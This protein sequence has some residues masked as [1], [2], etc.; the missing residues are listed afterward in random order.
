[1]PRFP[2]LWF[3]FTLLASLPALCLAQD[4][5]TY[6]G[7][8]LDETSSHAASQADPSKQSDVYLTND[9]FDKVYAFYKA[10]YPEHTMR[11]PPPKAP[12]GQQIKWAFFLVDGAKS[13]TTSKYWMKVQRPYVGGGDDKD[14]RDVT[15]I[16]T[17]HSK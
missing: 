2:K 10:L 13:L 15:V 16:Q 3:A 7:A 5:K 14:V 8:K 1:M 6:P 12:T 11:T 4:F 17:V 9:P